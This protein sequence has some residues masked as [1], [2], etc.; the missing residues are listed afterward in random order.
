MGETTIEM[1]RV[2]R[3]SFTNFRSYD[4]LDLC[5][6]GHTTVLLG[7][8]AA[9]KTNVIEGVQ[10]V[11]AFSSFRHPAVSELI[12]EGTCC[13]RID[14]LVRSNRRLFDLD[15]VIE[16]G[17][18]SYRLHGKARRPSD[19]RTSLSAVAFSPDD[20]SIAKEGDA[21]RRAAFDD[22]G[23]QLSANYCQ[24]RKDYAQALRQK[25]RLLKDEAQDKLID[26]AD[27]M[28]A[29]VGAQFT[30]YRSA[31]LERLTPLVR[32]R[33]QELS[34][35]E[36]LSIVYSP[37][38]EC[39]DRDI[40]SVSA[41]RISRH[42][43]ARFLSEALE[44]KRKEERRRKRS[45]VGPHTDAISFVL[46]GRKVST[47][48]SQG[49]QRSVVLALKLAEVDLIEEVLHIQPVLL[50]DDVMSELDENRR[51]ALSQMVLGSMQSFITTTNLSYFS[52]EVLAEANIIELPQGRKRL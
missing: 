7:S 42:D 48:A 50:L 40:S 43:A 44:R 4:R 22:I 1:T 20:L 6:L 5:D 27:D 35:G 34:S 30:A 33:Y 52:D 49:Q 31:L 47:F 8:N 36:E 37:S 24:V 29:Y 38:W 46:Q 32:K 26:A 9:G 41:Y 23:E 25:N 15:L 39:S 21:Y 3:I 11:T 45:L 51:T 18:R 19:L 2:E 13:G 10:L 14:A 12:K 28:I 16:E 17:K